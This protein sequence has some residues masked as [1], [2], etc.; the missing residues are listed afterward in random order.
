MEPISNYLKKFQKVLITAG[1][2]ENAFR[3]AAELI[4]KGDIGFFSLSQKG[5]TLFIRATPMVK[6]AIL[7]NQKKIL[8]EFK[9]RSGL[10]FETIK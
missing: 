4:L 2:T 7:L 3:Q 8:N 5:D 10:S 1:S 9:I 6:N